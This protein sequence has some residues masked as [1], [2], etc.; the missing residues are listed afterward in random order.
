M[1]FT[2]YTQLESILAEKPQQ[3]VYGRVLMIT[4]I[5]KLDGYNMHLPSLQ[6]G[7][8]KTAAIAKLAVEV[9]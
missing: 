9:S 8:N 3:I 7:V 1:I 2:S 4:F 5:Y 6:L